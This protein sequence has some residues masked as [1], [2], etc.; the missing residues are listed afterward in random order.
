MGFVVS[1][2]VECARP[3]VAI[4]PT[5]SSSA[6]VKS[7]KEKGGTM[8]KCTSL[9]S[10]ACSYLGTLGC[11]DPGLNGLKERMSVLET[12]VHLSGTAPGDCKEYMDLLDKID[13]RTVAEDMIFFAS[14]FFHRVSK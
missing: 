10:N 4:P 7:D 3:N 6:S 13:D 8:E 5:V 9:E 1:S 11:E 12:R 14:C 2:S